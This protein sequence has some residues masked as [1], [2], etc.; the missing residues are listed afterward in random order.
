MNLAYS[1][2]LLKALLVELV[3]GLDVVVRIDRIGKLE[4]LKGSTTGGSA[5]VGEVPGA[6]LSVFSDDGE[7]LRVSGKLAGEP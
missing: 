5:K 3:S 6:S 4:S 2:A 7:S 1:A